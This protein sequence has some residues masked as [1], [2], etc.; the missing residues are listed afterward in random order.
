MSSI[1]DCNHLFGVQSLPCGFQE[2]RR[3]LAVHGP[4]NLF[5]VCYI[6]KETRPSTMQIGNYEAGSDA[7]LFYFMLTDLVMQR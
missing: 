7:V 5:S 6:Y 3:T 4:R 1:A 2:G